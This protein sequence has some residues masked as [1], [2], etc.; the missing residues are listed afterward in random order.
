MLSH[1]DSNSSIRV[2]VR[3]RPPPDEESDSDSCI[4][5]L[6]KQVGTRFIKPSPQCQTIKVGDKGPN[7]S[8]D[9]VLPPPTDQK[10][11]YSACVHSLVQ[12]CLEGYNASILAY[13][14][15]GSGKTHTMIGNLGP[16]HDEAGIIPR[17]LEDIFLCLG[18]RAG[19][20]ALQIPSPKFLHYDTVHNRKNSQPAFE[21]QVKVQFLELY[22]EEIY[23]L[24]CEE[25]TN[26]TQS[27]VMKNVTCQRLKVGKDTEIKKAR[28]LTIRDGKVGE[29]AEVIGAC[30]AKVQSSEE[31][32]KYLRRGMKMRRTEQTAKNIVSSRSHAI[33]TFIIQQTQRK[34]STEAGNTIEM[35]TSKFHFVDL[36]GSERIK[37]TD[38]TGKRM[39]E[40]ININKGLLALAN[41][42]SSL[43]SES[44]KN[45]NHVPYRDSKLTRLL[46]GSLGGNHM[47]LMIGCA[48]PSNLNRDE[49]T[50]T[51]QYANRVRNIKNNAKVNKDPSSTVV[52]E[53]QDQVTALAMELL[54][55]ENAD[56][57]ND[58]KSQISDEFLSSLILAGGSSMRLVPDEIEI[59]TNTTFDQISSL[60]VNRN[61]QS[62]FHD[63]VRNSM[64]DFSAIKY[65]EEKVEGEPNENNGGS[66]MCRRRTWRKTF[67][68][69][70]RANDELDEKCENPK[71]PSD[72]EINLNKTIA[73]YDSMRASMRDILNGSIGDRH[74]IRLG[75]G[76]DP[77]STEKFEGKDKY[78]QHT[79]LDPA[80]IH[81][82]SKEKC[83]HPNK[84]IARTMNEHHDRYEALKLDNEIK[85]IKTKIE[86]YTN[87][88]RYLDGFI[89]Q[90]KKKDLHDTEIEKCINVTEEKIEKIVKEKCA[91]LGSPNGQLMVKL[92]PTVQLMAEL[93]FLNI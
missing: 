39:Q 50:N 84:N 40:G 88:K 37:T 10:Q 6:P 33:F 91:L 71:K 77:N 72:P 59:G 87:E 74:D 64:R 1:Q 43:S 31:A 78:S 76:N 54:R 60:N 26:R 9:N 68:K 46:K 85:L 44:Q 80:A 57:C 45:I 25:V 56:K 8:F 61:E 32:L 82:D 29:D 67:T 13:G 92:Y 28:R 93:Y 15:T 27:S 12:S 41:V 73:L 49:T 53:L 51:L 16:Q 90:L 36:A 35:K 65:S 3:I 34:V 55:V 89:D 2:V 81:I 47:T 7:F 30:Q 4:H 62:S 75:L 83:I 48:S 38:T 69:G 14:Q 52:N 17:A 86:N 63:L 11:F 42:I 5:V 79:F 18:Q 20:P 58:I 21:Y 70:P 22:G 66:K 23:D 19:S 24:V